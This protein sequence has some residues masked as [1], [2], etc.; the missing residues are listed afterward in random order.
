MQTFCH[1]FCELF[2]FIQELSEDPG[3]YD[4]QVVNGKELHLNMMVAVTAR[5]ML[6]NMMMGAETKAMV[7][8]GT[9]MSCLVSVAWQ[10]AWQ[11]FVTSVTRW[12]CWRQKAV[13]PIQPSLV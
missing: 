1:I 13:W 7:M 11:A 6:M 10:L 3:L 9:T 5:V 2:Y 4:L 8:K 12:L